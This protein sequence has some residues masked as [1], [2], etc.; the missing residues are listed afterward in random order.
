MYVVALA[1]GL[2]HVFVAAQ[3]GHHAQFYLTVVC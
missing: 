1:E 2:D 3:V